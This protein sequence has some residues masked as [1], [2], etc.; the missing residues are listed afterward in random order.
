MM[1]SIVA[2]TLY[3]WNHT[4]IYNAFVYRQIG[5]GSEA[6]KVLGYKLLFPYLLENL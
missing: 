3:L 2:A 4:L 1:A 5:K 6:G